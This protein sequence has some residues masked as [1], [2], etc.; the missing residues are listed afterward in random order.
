MSQKVAKVFLQHL[1][2]T[3][4]EL[5]NVTNIRKSKFCGII[6]PLTV[7]REENFNKNV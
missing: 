2:K 5:L 4:R 1:N 7:G 6:K 3:S